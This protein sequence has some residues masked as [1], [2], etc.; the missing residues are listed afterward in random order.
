MKLYLLLR[1][2]WHCMLVWQ[3]T[4]D[5]HNSERIVAEA[6]AERERAI[7]L[8]AHNTRRLEEAKQRATISGYRIERHSRLTSLGFK[9]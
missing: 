9:P 4:I 5:V 6:H 3:A 7:A 2:Q 1:H 8:D